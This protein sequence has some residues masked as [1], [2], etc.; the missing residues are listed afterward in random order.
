MII[1]LLF[2]VN[3]EAHAL[4]A[5]TVVYNKY[6]L[7]INKYTNLVNIKNI[8]NIDISKEK[9]SNTVYLVNDLSSGK[10]FQMPAYSLMLN[11]KQRVDQ[12][13]IISR[14]ANAIK[15]QET[16]GVNAYY[17][18]S[19]S[20]Q[21]CGAYQYMT[22]T[23]DNFMGY[24]TACL[25]PEWVQDA[26]IIHELQFN[27]GRFHDWRKAVAAHLYP[28]R[29]NNMNS[30]NKPVPGNPTVYQYVTSVFQKANIAY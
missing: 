19:Y 20:S 24:K 7:Y 22:E 30:W 28:A 17:R 26:R 8:I 14:L 3:S 11:L 23:W 10:T 12:R 15:S 25:A 4:T 27:Y 13:V 6:I 2:G 1:T 16:G 5:Q 29:A 18:K 21:A 9:S